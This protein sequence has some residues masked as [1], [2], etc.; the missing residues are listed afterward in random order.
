[1]TQRGKEQAMEQVCMVVHLLPGKTADA[2]DFMP[3][4]GGGIP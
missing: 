1:M 3:E 2:R 4:Q